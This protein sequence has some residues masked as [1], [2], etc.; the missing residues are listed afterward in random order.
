[1][2][3]VSLMIKDL[4]VGHYINLPIGWTSHP[5]ILNSFLIKDE[6]QLRIV[7]HLGLATISVDLSRSKLSQPQSIAAV[8]IASQTPEL[9]Q[10][11]LIAAQAVKI[12]QDTDAAEEKQ[13]LLT[14]LAQQQAWWKQIRHSRSKYQDKIASLKDIYSKLSLQPEKAMQLLELLSGELA[15][16]AE[17]QHDFSFAL[18]NEALSSD[19]LYQNAMN[20]AVL[21]TCLAKQLAFSRQDIAMVIHTALLSQFGMLWVPASIRNKK[22]E[23]TKPEV[24]YLKQHP[25][26]AAQR[27]QGITTLPESII[28]SILQV[29]EKFDGS[30]YPRGLKQDKIS[31][32]A[33]LVA[34]T[35]RYNEMCNANLPQH[36]YSPHLA[37]GLLF[38]Q[39]N[40]HYNK[41]Y[42]EQFIKMI[43]IFPVGTIVNYGNNHQAQVQMGVV[44]SLRQPLIV[45][46]DELEPIKKQSLLRHCRDEDI[47]IAKWV[48][49]DDIAAEHLAKF[50]LVQRNNLYF[51]S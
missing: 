5:F 14:Q 30:G 45:D 46:L 41:A 21:S 10:S 49:S 51:S 47:T 25:A 31:K 40:K 32:Y 27:L 4:Q 13:Q 12:Q 3:N 22:S 8:T 50:N 11:A 43:G 19:T 6:K 44:D 39:A 28:H 16:A 38:K 26:Y 34:I 18:C 17:Q 1:M 24:N 36:R 2:E 20:V 29:N 48:S 37:I 33:Q 15:I 23:L 7:Q 9:T 42:L 35:T